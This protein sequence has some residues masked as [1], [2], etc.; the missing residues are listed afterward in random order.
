MTRKN[1][2]G[3][4]ALIAVGVVAVLLLIIPLAGFR[5]VDA[6]EVAVVTRFGNPT[7]RVLGPGAHV[8]TPFIEGTNYINTKFLLYETMKSEDQKQSQSDYKETQVDTNTSDGQPVDIYYT[9]RFSIDPTKAIW[10]VQKFGSEQALVDKIVRAE[11]RSAARVEPSNF[12]A[13]ALYVGEGKT[14]LAEAIDVNIRSKL[15]ENGIILDQVLIREIQFT[16]NYVSAIE[17]KQIEEVKVDTAKNIAA[18]AEF[19][20][21]ASVRAAEA[22]AESQRLQSQTITETFLE[23]EWIAKWDGKLPQYMLGGDAIPLIQLPQ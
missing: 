4:A 12:S 13:D 3:Y 15:E 19:E 2:G 23:K 10:V 14:K 18:R 16:P 22:Q 11:S 6:G 1:N 17:A 8:I 5:Q 9:I 20:K 21:E 7:G